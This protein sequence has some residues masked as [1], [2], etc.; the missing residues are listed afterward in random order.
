[1]AE[2]DNNA[3]AV[4][5]V[6]ESPREAGPGG[7]LG[8]IPVEWYPTAVL[9]DG[10][11][12]WVL[13]GKGRGTAPNPERGHPGHRKHRDPLQDTLGQTSGSLTFLARPGEAELAR[14]S[15]RVAAANGW[16]GGSDEIEGTLPPFE[17][18][19]YIIREN[20]TFDQVFGDL[21]GC[22]ADTSLLLPR[23]ITPNAHALAGRFGIYDRFPR[24]RGR[25]RRRHSWTT[26]AYASVMSRETVPSVYSDRGR[27]YD[28]RERTGIRS[29]R[30]TSTSRPTR[31]L[32]DA[33]AQASRATTV[34]HPQAARRDMDRA[35]TIP[36]RCTD[37]K[38]PGWD[39]DVPTRCGPRAGS[40]S[41]RV[42]CGPLDAGSLHPVAPER[43]H[44][45][46]RGRLT[47]PQ[48]YAADNDLAVGMVIEALS[49]PSTG[50][51]HHLCAGGRCAGRA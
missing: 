35:Q 31:Y 34:G 29:R 16:Q 36:G 2:A 24:E 37:P 21:A 25:Q 43:P 45:G 6:G 4:F 33:A 46:G 27:T 11:S 26:A 18:V 3:V 7:L 23:A 38:Y 30:T 28:Y 22:D 19:I 41:S 10:D 9:A 40:R 20:R 15:G 13:N 1:V 51:Y 32:W 8:R 12:L 47:T 49:P 48:A 14:L 17:H 5:A 44:R 42:G 50:Q 39:L